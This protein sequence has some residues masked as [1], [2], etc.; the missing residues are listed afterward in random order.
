MTSRAILLMNLGATALF[1]DNISPNVSVHMEDSIGSTSQ[2]AFLSN[3][4][5]KQCLID[6]LAVAVEWSYCCEM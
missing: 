4:H 6:L 5:N 3:I 2:K 1:K